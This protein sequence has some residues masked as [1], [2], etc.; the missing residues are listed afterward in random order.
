MEDK[1]LFSKIP[2][3]GGFEER[4]RA[5]EVQGKKKNK[6]GTE[7]KR[8]LRGE[9]KGKGIKNGPPTHRRGRR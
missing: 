4:T 3:C 1:I 9:K 2:N 5:E 6:T 7:S 8:G